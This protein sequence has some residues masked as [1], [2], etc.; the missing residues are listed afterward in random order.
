M[1][2]YVFSKNKK[3]VDRILSSTSSGGVTVND[4]LMHPSRK[5]EFEHFDD[6]G[7]SFPCILVNVGCLSIDRLCVVCGIVKWLVFRLSTWSVWV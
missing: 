7:I 6:E 4:T 1:A 5:S 3:V 2:L